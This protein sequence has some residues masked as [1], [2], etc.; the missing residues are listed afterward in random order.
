MTPGAEPN[1][2]KGKPTNSVMMH[3]SMRISTAAPSWA[4]EDDVITKLCDCTPTT[5]KVST[6]ELNPPIID[7]IVPMTAPHTFLDLP[8]EAIK[9]PAKMTRK[10]RTTARIESDQSRM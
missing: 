3:P 9:S 10:P 4:D 2:P 6:R 5:I 1:M 7:A 8:F